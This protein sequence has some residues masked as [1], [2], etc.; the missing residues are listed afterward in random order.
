[1]NGQHKHQQKPK[2]AEP[3]P[4]HAP[5]AGKVFDEHKGS[6]PPAQP[7]KIIECHR[8]FFGSDT[9]RGYRICRGAPPHT[10]YRNMDSDGKTHADAL[11]PKVADGDWCGAGVL[12]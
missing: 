5:L 3:A 6:T 7:R 2:P 1:M 12:V 4:S 9:S 8:C 10:I 11:W